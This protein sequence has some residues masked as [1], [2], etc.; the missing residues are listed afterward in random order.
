MN[1]NNRI[2]RTLIAAKRAFLTNTMPPAPK[3]QNAAPKKAPASKPANAPAAP[4]VPDPIILTDN[5]VT[6]NDLKHSYC[7]GSCMSR[8]TVTKIIQPL[9]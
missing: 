2:I 6:I 7:I 1:R 8:C 9:Y 3:Q 5:P 4:V